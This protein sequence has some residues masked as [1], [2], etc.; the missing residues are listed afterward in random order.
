M[1][2]PMI[3]FRGVTKRYGA[4]TVLDHLD[5]DVARNEKDRKSVV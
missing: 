5:L 3:R 1:T 4:L 2:T